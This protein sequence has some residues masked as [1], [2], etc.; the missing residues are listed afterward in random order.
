M[1][2]VRE[3]PPDPAVPGLG[4]ALRADSL[5]ELLTDRLH[6]CRDGVRFLDGRLVDVQYTPGVG[7]HVLWKIRA[8]DPDTGRTGRQL[9]FVRALRVDEPIPAAPVE[10]ISKYRDLR[11]SNGMA[12]GMPFRTPWLV[13]QDAR[14]IVHAFPLDP[15][16]PS[17]LNI[18]HPEAMRVALQHLWQARGA[19]VR[20]VH[21]DTLSYTP[22]ARAALQYEVLGEDA[23][24]QLPELRRL[25]GKIDAR[26]P[27]S[28]LFA[29][30]WAVWRAG[31]GRVCIAPPVGYVAVARL[32]L[33]EFLTG[34]RLSE[35]TEIGELK[36][37]VRKAA[38]AIATVHALEAPVVKHR[39]V[40]KEMSNVERWGTVLSQ[41]RPAQATRLDGLSRRLRR[42]VAERM[43]ITATIHA[44]FHLANILTDRNG[45]TLIDWDQA[46][47]GDP[48]L[49][50]GRLLASLR[51][52]SL[53]MNGKLDGLAAVGDSFLEAYLAKT[54]ESVPRARLFEAATLL[55]AAA[56]PFRLQREGWEESADLI[57]DEVERILD[58]SLAGP[59][60]AGTPSGFKREIAFSDRPSWA[61]DKVYAQALLVLVVHEAYGTHIEVTET[62]PRIRS[63]SQNRIHIQW[64]LKGFR[65]EERWSHTVEGVGFPETSGRNSLHR[66]EHAHAAA[67]KDPSAVQVPRPLGRI[68]PLSLLVFE[69][70]RGER[71]ISLLGTNRESASVDAL[72]LALARFH[73]LDLQLTKDRSS[74]RVFAS[75]TR[76]VRALAQSGHPA[77][78]SARELLSALSLLFDGMSERRAPTVLPFSLKSLRVTDAGFA[79][80][81]VHDVVMA[82][83]LLNVASLIAELT[84][85][86]LEREAPQTAADRF[87]SSYRDA[88]GVSG[89]DL[90][91]WE[92]VLLL[93]LGCVIA[94][95][96]PRSPL[97][98][99]MIDIARERLEA[100]TPTEARIM[101]ASISADHELVHGEDR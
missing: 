17:L 2:N 32:S 36:G 9:V 19:R 99:S 87:R 94:L 21:V 71:F 39:S 42:E 27:P 11:A 75:L 86:A 63:V 7:A 62:I 40:E 54:D 61:T 38:H 67:A 30:H 25:V 57:I 45:V 60:V 53:R 55:T 23:G 69:P 80:S 88:S 65:G 34:K 33:Q 47:H 82:N 48:M 18:A 59:R 64:K 91:I 90:A 14:V 58:L 56:T 12:R 98:Q 49:D 5:F 1:T 77:A 29:G 78:D 46:A 41:L 95:R 22:G 96:D 3:S 10:L 16:M 52:A 4:F 100:A 79:T 93:R 92:A 37:R 15:A 73:S 68:A 44:D 89:A 51:V 83:P 13:A 70:P 66:L 101:T 24:S 76:R 26:R 97:S 50:V 72:A 85:N 84:C 6:E 31:S 74:A 35:I 8:Y 20:R 28:R 81:P 43:R